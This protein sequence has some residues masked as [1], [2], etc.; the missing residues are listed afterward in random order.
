MD[1]TFDILKWV[2]WTVT[3][4]AAVEGSG[5]ELTPSDQ[6]VDQDDSTMWS[7]LFD[8]APCAIAIVD[9]SGKLTRV[10]RT[11]CGLLGYSPAELTNRPLNDLT[12]DLGAW[13]SGTA[14]SLSKQTFSCATA[15]T[16]CALTKQN[17]AM[18]WCHQIVVPGGDRTKRPQW[19]ICYFEEVRDS[20]SALRLLVESHQKFVE[21]QS[22]QLETLG[23]ELQS[24]GRLAKQLGR[25]QTLLLERQVDHLLHWLAPLRRSMDRQEKQGALI[26][27]AYQSAT[28]MQR[29]VADALA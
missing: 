22:A 10:N 24:V 20:T 9:F 14:T 6:T 2:N 29:I 26:E 25:E 12:C 5:S 28:Q 27:S 11:F 13:T 17:G 19:A 3:D 15:E 8:H 23:Q 21:Q 18:V 16:I 4:L 1:S 7:T